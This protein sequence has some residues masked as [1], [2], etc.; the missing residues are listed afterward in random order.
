[1][2]IGTELRPAD[3]HRSLSSFHQKGDRDEREQRT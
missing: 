2:W 3:F 1:L